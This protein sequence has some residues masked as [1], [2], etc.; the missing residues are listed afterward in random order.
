MTP[1]DPG[2]TEATE[3]RSGPRLRTPNHTPVLESALILVPFIGAISGVLLAR[4]L[5]PTGRGYVAAFGVGVQFVGFCCG[6]SLDKGLIHELAI[7][8]G[9]GQAVWR[10]AW[11]PTV[12]LAAAAGIL[13]VVW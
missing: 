9:R 7:R 6:L 13:G 11:R 10:A 8:G 3:D 1:A 12:P 5:G 2:S 4:T